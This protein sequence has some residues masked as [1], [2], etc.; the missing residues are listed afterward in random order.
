VS[1]DGQKE[2]LCRIELFFFLLSNRAWS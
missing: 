1:G 2:S